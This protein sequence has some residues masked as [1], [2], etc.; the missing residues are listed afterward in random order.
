[1]A[2]KQ[3][4]I[5]RARAG[6]NKAANR[7]RAAA[8]SLP[9]TPL[10][11][12]SSTANNMPSSTAKNLSSS[13]AN[14]MPS[15]ATDSAPPPAAG[16]PAPVPKAASGPRGEASD[17]LAAAV[18]NQQ[19]G[20]LEAAL[21]TYARALR[22]D[23]R[24]PGIYNNMGV[25]LRAQGKLTAA[26]AAYGRSVAL[27]PG[28]A[29]VH[30]NLGNALR[31]A[32]RFED[33]VKSH[34]RALRLKPR[35]A[36]FIYNLGLIHRDL[37]QTADALALFDKALALA[38][39]YVDCRWD[40]AVILLRKGRF[41]EGFRE[42]EWRWKMAQSPP[43]DPG[44]PLWDGADL[45]GRAILV[46]QEQGFG[47]MIQFARYI[48]LL[49]KKGAGSVIVEAQRPLLRLFSLMDGVDRVVARKEPPGDFDV[50]APMLSLPRLFATTPMTIP[51]GVPYL[52]APDLRDPPPVLARDWRLKVG[53]SWAGRPSHKNDRNR[54][55][56]LDRFVAI[57]RDPRIAFF[58]LQKGP[59]RQ[60]LPRHA[61]PALVTD[62]GTG[63]RDFAEMAAVLKHL[64]LV[65][66][67][68]TAQAHLAG[69]LARPAWVVLPFN[70]DWRWQDGRPDSA[71]YPTLRL[72][73]Q[74]RPGDWDPV[75]AAVEDAL[76]LWTDEK[77]E[78]V[79]D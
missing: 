6:R 48:P 18:R 73:R 59:P 13:T 75:F 78:I 53:I 74:K 56:S 76:K 79:R 31:E 63:I 15:S 7:N 5:A 60:D 19:R 58:S 38:P 54:S 39:D 21:S 37:C 71:W 50:Y 61:T 10:H 22:F 9:A 57:A 12:P 3:P 64:D 69:A 11:R 27:D 25:A 36:Q 1:M 62:L 28:N 41:L 34:F 65:I 4:R 70:A 40:R 29:A 42:Y 24:N 8:R 32:G 44:R 2:T 77:A 47:D 35:S 67:V 52:R 45:A 43:R 49:R 20:D 68:D 72:F 26:I 33:S 51:A 66:T 16:S 17:L 30:S 55:V 23:P 14:N 46:Q